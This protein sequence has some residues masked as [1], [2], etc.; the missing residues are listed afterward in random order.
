MRGQGPL[1]SWAGC[2]AGDLTTAPSLCHVFTVPPLG[3]A[4]RPGSHVAIPWSGCQ[5]EELLGPR[6]PHRG[7]HCAFSQLGCV[8]L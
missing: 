8:W 1:M 2:L 5:R 6:G 7:R 3:S 4:Q